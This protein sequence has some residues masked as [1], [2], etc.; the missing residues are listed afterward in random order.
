MLYATAET[1]TW[2]FLKL[3]SLKEN[4]TALNFVAFVLASGLAICM[5]VFLSSTQGFV[6]GDILGVPS[7]RLGD[8]SGNLTLFDECVS[9]V[10]VYAWGVYS[11]RIGRN[12][13]YGLGF[14]LIGAGLV[15][16]P[17]A[18]SYNSDLIVYRALYA[19]GAAATSSMLTAVLAD[20]AAESDRGK[21]SGLVGLMSGV[22]AL[23]AVF[24]FLPLP[25]KF[26][27][28]VEGL[29]ISY[30]VV[31]GFAVL[32]GL[33]LFFAL[34]PK[35]VNDAALL[36]QAHG[37]APLEPSKPVET[38]SFVAGFKAGIAAAKDGKVLLGYMGSFLARGDTIII[39]IFLPL[40]V[41]KYYIE[42]HLCTAT[43]V[44]SPD[45]KDDCRKAYIVASI[46]G[47]V[48]QTAALVSA[49]VFGY[50]GDRVY[51]PLV[52]LASTIIGGIGYFWLYLSTDP[53]APIMY[54]V[55]VVV[56]I[57]EMGIVV[58]S[59]SLVTSKAI[60]CQL[61]GSVSGAY[62]FF[63]TI[64]I[65]ITSKLGGYLF[66]HW[67]STAPF[68]IMAVGNV[69]CAVVA[70]GVMLQD[71]RRAQAIATE[72]RTPLLQSLQKMQLE[73]DELRL[74]H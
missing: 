15:A 12:G 68:F 17:Y 16:Y 9:L 26:A 46:V 30:A 28:A 10:M 2:K 67:T 70:I 49:P 55:A 59:L 25:T 53:T 56:G 19:V 1:R 37:I 40:W 63:G 21:V 74:L 64:G 14:V 22:G 13:I 50:I 4:V 58:S 39:T 31:G 5:Y 29:R 34:R 33:F 27:S 8:I 43:D 61:R 32:F 69:I 65:L 11:D 51:R 6:L 18:T 52:V 38:P 36:S 42:H 73:Q 23:L 7:A 41:Y 20:Y 45:I 71:L 35:A 66:D 44:N 3:V 47:G 48:V 54:L 57:G 62:S 24:V 72:E 60:P